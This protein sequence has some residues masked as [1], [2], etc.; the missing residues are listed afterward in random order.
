MIRFLAI[1][2]LVLLQIFVISRGQ[3]LST[4]HVDDPFF[5][6]IV[7]FRTEAPLEDILGVTYHITGSLQFDPEDLTGDRSEARFEVELTTLDTGIDLR[8][9]DLKEEYLHTDQYPTAVFTLEKIIRAAPSRLEPNKPILLTASGTFALHGVTRNMEV[10]MKVTY[11]PETQVT[12]F[13]LPGNLLKIVGEFDVNLAD[14]AIEIPRMAV[15]RVGEV[16][17]VRLDLFATDAEPTILSNW[18]DEVGAKPPIRE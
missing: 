3:T 11:L 15:L 4:F 13:K 14:Y 1:F 18:L 7:Q 6:N 17:H 2:S 12:R 16:A 10:E 9:A 5:R 8:N